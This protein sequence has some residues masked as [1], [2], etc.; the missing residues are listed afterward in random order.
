[1]NSLFLPSSS[2]YFAFQQGVCYKAIKIKRKNMEDKKQK[3]LRNLP[4]VEEILQQ[5]E[6]KETSKSYPRRLVVDSIKRVIEGKRMK[7]LKEDRDN[8][9]D[10]IDLSLETLL[11]ITLKDIKESSQ[12]RLRKIIN[13]T[14]VIIHTNIGRSVLSQ[15]VISHISTIAGSYSNL[16]YD[17]KLGKRGSRNDN[18]VDIVKEITGA[19]F[20]LVVNNNA[21]AVLVSLDTLSSGKEVIVSR[22]ELVEIGGSFRIPDIM[23]KTSAILREIGTTNKTHLDDYAAAINKNTGLILKVHKS[24]F[25]MMGFTKEVPLEELVAL[26]RKHNIPVM[27][28][29][30]SGNLIDIRKYGL[31]G[32]PTA[33]ESIKKGADV[34]T[35]SGDKLL[36]G[37]QAGIIIGRESYIN[38]IKKNPLHRTVRI[39][40][41]TLAGIE[42][43]LRLYLD[44]EKAIQSIPT[45]KM[46]T[47][48]ITELERKAEKLLREMENTETSAIF[49]LEIQGNTSEVGGG[50]LPLQKLLTRVLSL[51]PKTLSVDFVEQ[52][53]R[54]YHPSILGRIYKDQFLF[55]LRT[56]EETDFQ[57]IV[58]AFIGLKS[59]QE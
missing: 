24:N 18:I 15:E 39:D 52:Y 54:S 48:P 7:I 23:G 55:D 59:L 3:L 5:E 10:K 17:L 13:A 33:Q 36:G 25:K 14:G 2:K 53:F 29:L 49:D 44:E 4:S 8:S 42:A 34:V 38:A 22:G 47:M 57:D 41:M 11:K 28:D 26:G 56:I 46:L 58:N 1:M 32:E 51:K 20:A 16:E 12:Y 37:P 50:A 9:F 27:E 21:A 6:I 35:F 40:K 30:G 19:E 31:E 45:L 43:T